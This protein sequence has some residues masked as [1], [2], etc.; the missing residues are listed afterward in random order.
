MPASE[1][2]QFWLDRKAFKATS[3]DASA[4]PCLGTP[5]RPGNRREMTRRHLPC[6]WSCGGLPGREPAAAAGPGSPPPAS[7]GRS[8]ALLS[9]GLF[10]ISSMEK[11]RPSLFGASRRP[12]LVL[13][14]APQG[15]GPSGAHGAGGSEEGRRG[16]SCVLMMMLVEAA[17]FLP[18]TPG[19]KRAG[20]G[21]E[22]A[23]SGRTIQ[24]QLHLRGD[25]QGHWETHLGSGGRWNGLYPVSGLR[26]LASSL[27]SKS[28]LLNWVQS[29]SEGSFPGWSPL[30]SPA[31]ARVPEVT[32]IE[33]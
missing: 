32:A 8:K 12:E 9:P 4:F 22:W 26:I 30:Q 28:P 21:G 20:R 16:P 6:G 17:R 15:A 24:A 33:E 14:I 18:D 25:F 23:A 3:P 11:E 7:S 19:I 13:S 1:K 5:G 31:K 2:P 27:S 10:K 29:Y